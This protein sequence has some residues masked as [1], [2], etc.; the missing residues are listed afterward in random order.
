MEQKNIEI[1]C[2]VYEKRT[3]LV[4]ANSRQGIQHTSVVFFLQGAFAM[5][6]MHCFFIRNYPKNDRGQ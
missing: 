2:L 5:S 1:F 3:Q 4:A 6:S